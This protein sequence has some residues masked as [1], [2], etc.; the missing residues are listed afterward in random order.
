MIK[1]KNL[2]VILLIICL[3]I[4]KIIKCERNS[5]KN[6][7][8]I[9]KSIDDNIM[10]VL[11]SVSLSHTIKREK[12]ILNDLSNYMQFL[13][14]LSSLDIEGMENEGLLII[15]KKKKKGNN[16]NFKIKYSSKRNYKNNIKDIKEEI[17]KNIYL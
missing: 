17:S 11:N 16:K 4:N 1:I 12:N 3:V 2:T 9:T 10:N 5:F 14:E 15:D 7:K 6:E 13:K 8:G